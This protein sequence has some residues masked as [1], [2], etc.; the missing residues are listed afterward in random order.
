MLSFL[1]TFRK[2]S[3][4]IGFISL[5]KKDRRITFYSEGANYWPHLEGPVRELLRRNLAPVNYISSSFDDPGLDIQNDNYH[6]FTIGDGTIRNWLFQ[7]IE[8]D[9]MIMTMPDLH[10]YQV[11]RSRHKVHY[12]YL[13]HSLVSLHMVYRSGA[14]DHYDTICCAGPHH[15]QEVQALKRAA[16]LPSKHIFEHGYSRL[17]S[18]IRTT[19]S[20][21]LRK[22]TGDENRKHILIAPSWGPKGVVES[23][24]AE[25]LIAELLELG[26]FVTFRPHPQTFKFAK[27]KT[28]D[29][30]TRYQSNPRFSFENNVSGQ[31]SLHRSDIMVSDWSG[32]A[33][34]YAFALQRPVIFCDVPKKVNNPDYKD[35]DLTPLEVSLREKI[36]VIWDGRENLSSCLKRCE[37]VEKNLR[38]GQAHQYVFNLGLSDQKFGDYM[39]ALLES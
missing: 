26:L 16:G 12:I 39:L 1:D 2:I 27:F 33:L 11:K 7:N 18:L 17:D 35:I 9:Y 5:P 36:G 8:T 37:T 29:I 24:L 32:A 4:V 31:E 25:T 3:D 22:K 6:A 19:Q 28:T 34:E 14:F 23:G 15:V 30:I 13:Q 21:A 10:R 20:H 38:Q